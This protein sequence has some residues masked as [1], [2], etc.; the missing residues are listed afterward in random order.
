MPSRD[1]EFN[2]MAGLATALLIAAAMLLSLY[3]LWMTL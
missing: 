1:E 3:V 2:S